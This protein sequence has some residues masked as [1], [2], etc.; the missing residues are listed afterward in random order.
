M[1][2][3]IDHR[4][5]SIISETARALEG[6]KTGVFASIEDRPKHVPAP[7]PEFKRED[8]IVLGHNTPIPEGFVKRIMGRGRGR[9]VTFEHVKLV[10]RL[11]SRVA[12][13]VQQDRDNARATAHDGRLP[14]GLAATPHGWQVGVSEASLAAIGAGLPVETLG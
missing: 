3:I 7:L 13:G 9:R 2:Y 6:V 1:S 12:K 10:T 8:W 5:P 4:S 14:D 11:P